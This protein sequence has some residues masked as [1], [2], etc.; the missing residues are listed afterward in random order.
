MREQLGAGVDRARSY[1]IPNGVDVQRFSP[2]GRAEARAR[3]GI[4]P[5]KRLVLFPNTPTEIRKRIDLARGAMGQLDAGG[6]KAE[7]WVVQGVPPRDMPDYF[8]AAD[9]LLLTSDWEGSANV[10][11][12]AIC[13]DLPVV[14]VDAGD[15]ARWVG[16]TNG[17]HLVDR[18]PSAIAEG[19]RAALAAPNVNGSLVREE[20]QI[21]RTASR[22]IGL[23]R[24][25]ISRRQ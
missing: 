6:V 18:N 12:E 4:D 5:G 1:V 16:M 21:A 2:G 3:L 7:L 13:C 9:C 19:L 17:C 25:A 14:S 20:L 23:Y 22:I 10:V 24:E 8:R 15:A 11:K